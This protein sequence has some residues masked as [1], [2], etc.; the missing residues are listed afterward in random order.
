MHGSD[1]NIYFDLGFY[2]FKSRASII[3]NQKHDWAKNLL[4]D[5]RNI[6]PWTNSPTNYSDKVG[7][8]KA[9]PKIPSSVNGEKHHVNV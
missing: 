7:V 4:T 3:G 6:P 5:A 2:I 8:T 9:A 1:K